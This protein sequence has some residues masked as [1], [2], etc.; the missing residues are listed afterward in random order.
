MT[1]PPLRALTTST[2]RVKG[3]DRVTSA[4]AHPCHS[5]GSGATERWRLGARMR[6]ASRSVV[7]AGTTARAAAA[8]KPVARDRRVDGT[9]LPARTSQS[10]L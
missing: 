4:T 6:E 8:R 1:R 7:V 9:A 10:G 2:W 5:A 3:A